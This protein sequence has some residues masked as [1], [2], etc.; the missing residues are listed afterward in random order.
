MPSRPAETTDPSE[1]SGSPDFDEHELFAASRV[2]AS[3]RNLEAFP[4]LHEMAFMMSSILGGLSLVISDMTLSS[5]VST[6]EGTTGTT[7][8]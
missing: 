7:R 4:R 5:S 6:R 1:S 8:R 2:A 3:L